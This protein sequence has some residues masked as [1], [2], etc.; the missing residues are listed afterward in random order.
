MAFSVGHYDAYVELDVRNE[1]DEINEDNNTSFLSFY[2]RPS[3]EPDSNIGEDKGTIQPMTD[4][5]PAPNIGPDVEAEVNALT[6]GGQPLPL[7]LR[8][9]F[10]PRFGY[11]F[12]YVRVHTDEKAQRSARRVNAHAYTIG[13]HI[14]LGRGQLD[15]STIEGR[16]LL[17]HELTHVIQQS[18][19]P[20]P[21]PI[22]VSL[23]LRQ[24][25]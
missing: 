19:G 3:N 13:N 12:S 17:A 8:T 9:F 14:V 16:R 5:C 11:D 7:S 23:P 18:N 2:V 4:G 10:E 20:A 21:E 6:G 22:P 1:V 25:L 15:S 24:A